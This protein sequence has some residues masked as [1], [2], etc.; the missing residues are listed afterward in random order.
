[1]VK[2]PFQTCVRN[3]AELSG[4]RTEKSDDKT[5]LKV[6][7]NYFINQSVLSVKKKKKKGSF[8]PD[9]LLWFESRYLKA[10]VLWCQLS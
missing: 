6:I 2:F 3:L 10:Y 5:F 1:M 4:R 8:Q 7:N 9:A